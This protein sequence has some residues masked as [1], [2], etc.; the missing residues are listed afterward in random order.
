MTQIFTDN[1]SRQSILA[2]TR[3]QKVTD[4]NEAGLEKPYRSA[5][6]ALAV[7]QAFFDVDDANCV[8]NAMFYLSNC[9]PV[10]FFGK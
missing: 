4:L 9:W 1:I 10:Y 3:I 6:A 7:D 2:D 5:G 8:R